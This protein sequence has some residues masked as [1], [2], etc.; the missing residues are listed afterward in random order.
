MERE[1]TN[2]VSDAMMGLGTMTIYGFTFMAGYYALDWVKEKNKDKAA[3]HHGRL[4]LRVL[5]TIVAIAMAAL[6]AYTHSEMPEGWVLHPRSSIME[7]LPQSQAEWS[8]YLN[9]HHGREK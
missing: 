6:A 4:S 1:M 2:V 7:G 3:T 5:A 9:E 8:A